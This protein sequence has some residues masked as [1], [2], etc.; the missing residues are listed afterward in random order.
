MKAERRITEIGE[1][2]IRFAEKCLCGEPYEIE[3][4]KP[5][6]ATCKQCLRVYRRMVWQI[7]NQ[8]VIIWGTYFDPYLANTLVGQF[9]DR[10]I[11]KL[12]EDRY[13]K[14]QR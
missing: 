7:G 8:Q 5:M 3:P 6:F 13:P 1:P 2:E 10:F 4:D 11:E 14:E 12:P 9:I